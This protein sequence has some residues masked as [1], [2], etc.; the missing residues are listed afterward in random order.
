MARR[1]VEVRRE[2]ILRA[3][4][5]EVVKRGFAHTRAAD[6]AAAL[7][8][9]TGL[10]F[11]H[12][13]S[14]DALLSAAFAYAAERDLDRLD[15]AAHGHRQRA[16]PPGAI[17]TMYG[18]EEHR[19]GLAAVGRRL[20]GGA[21]QPGDGRGLAAP[22]RAVE[23]HRRRRDPQGVEAGEMTCAD[24]NGAAWRITALLDGLAV[25][26]TVHEGVLTPRADRRRG[27]ASRP[28]PSSTW[29]PTALRD[30]PS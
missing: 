9:S 23:G 24:P 30:Q 22:R 29:T 16:A 27:C 5:D 12:F 1:K 28:P 7:G 15:A 21:A 17:L 20:G 26:A 6:V 14:K 19:R 8:I 3:T 10:I 4:C 18:P 13:D 25:Q 2:E 11:Y